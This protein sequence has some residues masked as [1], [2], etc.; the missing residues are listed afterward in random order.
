MESRLEISNKAHEKMM[1]PLQHTDGT[2]PE[3]Q[4]HTASVL[5]FKAVRTDSTHLLCQRVIT[6]AGVH[7]RMR[8]FSQIDM[9]AGFSGGR[10]VRLQDSVL[11]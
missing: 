9:A 6:V 8:G 10:G 11:R 7:H 5:F 2:E 1:G 3:T 4:D